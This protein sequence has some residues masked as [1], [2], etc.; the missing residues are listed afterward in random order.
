[1]LQMFKVSTNPLS[2]VHNNLQKMWLISLIGSIE[3]SYV[4]IIRD[5]LTP[6]FI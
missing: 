1:M 2:A 5:L 4:N 3:Q 6:D